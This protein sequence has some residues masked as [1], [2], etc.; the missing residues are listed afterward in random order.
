MKRYSHI[1][2]FVILAVALL[3]VIWGP[4]QAQSPNPVYDPIT[5]YVPEVISVRPHNTDA[6][7]EGLFLYDGS[8]YES[9]GGYGKSTLR[10]LD[11]QTGEILRSIDIPEQYFG[12]GIALVDD[13]LIQLTWKAGTA[14]IYDRAT[15]EQIGTYSYSGEGWGLCYDGR[16]LYMS[17]GSPFIQMRDPQTFELIFRGLVTL[18]GRM[19]E[20]LNELECVGDYIYANVWETDYIVQI[21]KTDGVAVG[22]IDTSNLVPADEKAQFTSAEVLNGIVYLP[23]SDTFLITGKNWPH[24]YEVKFVPQDQ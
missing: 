11:P 18:Q 22:V 9:S 24:M 2:P 21:D 10:E 5:V 19:V 14:F 3:A 4:V 12:E 6:F 7:T 16:Y 23:D 20:K 15:F 1:F 13:K 17:D 8:I